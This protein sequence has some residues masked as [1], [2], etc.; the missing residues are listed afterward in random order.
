MNLEQEAF[1]IGEQ[2]AYVAQNFKIGRAYRCSN[3][4]PEKKKYLTNGILPNAK[5][6]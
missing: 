5:T 6:V 3:L 4:G 2:I 1:V